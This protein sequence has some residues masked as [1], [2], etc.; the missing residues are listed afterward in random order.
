MIFVAGRGFSQQQTM[1]ASQGQP[2]GYLKMLPAGVPNAPTFRPAAF[3][4]NPIAANHYYTE[5]SFF[6]KKEIQLEKVI[7]IPFRFRLGSVEDCDRMEGKH[8]L[9]V[10]A[11]K[12]AYPPAFRAPGT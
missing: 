12:T 1:L 11:Y 4:N 8:K 7:K 10:P 6:C 5:L 3:Y 9:Q 2:V